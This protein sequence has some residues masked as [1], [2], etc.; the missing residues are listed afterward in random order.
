MYDDYHGRGYEPFAVNLGE[1]VETVKS[2]ARQYGFPFLRDAGYVAWNLYKMDNSNIPLNY[3]ID[4]A[5]LVVG[6]MED[7]IEPTIR[8]WIEPYLSGV[9]ES[10]EARSVEFVAVGQSPAVGRGAVR[11]NLPRAGTVS[12]RVYSSSGTLVRTVFDGTLAAGSNT[13]NWDLA[14]NG[15]RPVSNGLYVYELVSGSTV[16]RTKV[17]VLR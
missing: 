12:L 5:G 14:D 6:S 13:L 16:A 3:V 1:D 2:F 8:G 11:F 17:S 4:T 15:G 10:P 9:G 7:F